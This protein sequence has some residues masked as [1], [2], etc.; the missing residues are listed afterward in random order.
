MVSALLDHALEF[1]AAER[2]AWLTALPEHPAIARLYDAGLPRPRRSFAVWASYEGIS[3]NHPYVAQLR[4]EVG[5]CALAAGQRALAIESAK[6]VRAV[7]LRPGAD[8]Y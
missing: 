2:E 6:Q 4:A 7:P 5:L 1:P 8:R 3:P